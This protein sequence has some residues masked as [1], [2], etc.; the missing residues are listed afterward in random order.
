MGRIHALKVKI[1][2]AE[3][4]VSVQV[5]EANN[6]Q[7]LFGL[8]NMKRHRCCVDLLENHLKFNELMVSVPFLKE[9]EI[10]KENL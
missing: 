2:G 9:N 6:M 4:T 8:D 10:S 3:I 5:L 7:F 1:A